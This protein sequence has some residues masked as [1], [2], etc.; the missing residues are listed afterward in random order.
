M[1]LESPPL[2][3]EY[4]E[5]VDELEEPNRILGSLTNGDIDS[6]SSDSSEVFVDQPEEDEVFLSREVCSHENKHTNDNLQHIRNFQKYQAV[7]NVEEFLFCMRSN[8]LVVESDF[9]LEN[10]CEFEQV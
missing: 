1:Q 2:E 9:M 6:C 5:D 3:E 4:E 10:I 7:I 8:M